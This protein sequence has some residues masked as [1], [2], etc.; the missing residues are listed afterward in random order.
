ME[1]MKKL[2]KFCLVMLCSFGFF[3]TTN[4]NLLFPP[5]YKFVA[6]QIVNEMGDVTKYGNNCEFGNK[7]CI[8][9][10]CGE[11]FSE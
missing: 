11:G 8:P 1:K 10:P 9:N 7:V 3:I 2:I 5:Y 4:A 6:C